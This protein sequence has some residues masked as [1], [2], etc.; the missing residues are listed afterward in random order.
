MWRAAVCAERSVALGL[1]GRAFLIDT[2]SMRINQNVT[3][4]LS[5]PEQQNTEEP[6]YFMV[7]FINNGDRD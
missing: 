3:L 2:S 4:L 1:R 5:D 6:K 7:K